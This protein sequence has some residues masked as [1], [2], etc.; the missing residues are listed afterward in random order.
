[1]ASN[2]WILGEM[3]DDLVLMILDAGIHTNV[4]KAITIGEAKFFLN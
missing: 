4:G 2:Q 1:M 3:L